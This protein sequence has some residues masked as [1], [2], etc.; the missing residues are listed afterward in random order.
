MDTRGYGIR[1]RPSSILYHVRM[2]SFAIEK[3]HMGSENGTVGSRKK[4]PFNQSGTRLSFP[5]RRGMQ[6]GGESK[7]T[8]AI[9]KP[10]AVAWETDAGQLE[11][12]TRERRQTQVFCPSQEEGNEKNRIERPLNSQCGEG[13]ARPIIS[14]RGKTV[15]ILQGRAT[16]SPEGEG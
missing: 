12:C 7:V 8:P 10:G 13:R 4:A 2:D 5:P 9:K 6:T 16:A 3:A 11:R 15:A 1:N 14:K